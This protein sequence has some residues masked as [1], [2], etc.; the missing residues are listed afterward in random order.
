MNDTLVMVPRSRNDR[1][2][3]ILALVGIAAFAV[4]FL[5]F[6]PVLTSPSTIDQITIRNGTSYPIDVA[7]VGTSS[8]DWLPLGTADT[9]DS[10][11]S[12]VLDPGSV[13]LVRFTKGDLVDTVRVTR[14][15]LE[16]NRWTILVPAK[17]DSLIHDAGND[18]PT[19][20]GS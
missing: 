20:I 2:D 16:A 14:A 8:A 15:S 13:W 7:V 4:L 12:D 11:F 3:R 9:G 1:T 5:I 19:S 18:V 10:Q 6:T 17:L